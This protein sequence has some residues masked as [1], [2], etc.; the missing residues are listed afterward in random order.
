MNHTALTSLHK[1][2]CTGLITDDTKHEK[3]QRTWTWHVSIS[4][5]KGIYQYIEIVTWSLGKLG[6]I[7]NPWPFPVVN[8]KFLWPTPTW[9]KVE[10]ETRDLSLKTRQVNP[11][12]IKTHPALAFYPIGHMITSLHNQ[13]DSVGHHAIVRPTFLGPSWLN[14]F[15]YAPSSWMHFIARL[16]ERTSLQKGKPVH[17]THSITWWHLGSINEL[18]CIC[19][20]SH[21]TKANS[22]FSRGWVL[23]MKCI[24]VKLLEAGHLKFSYPTFNDQNVRHI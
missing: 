23:L 5:Y 16:H 2:V 4:R 11:I 9:I 13:T 24:L 12:H 22:T 1:C 19:L 18:S 7:V 6:W 17:I 14:L 10:I 3:N 20:D 8:V 21:A 15:I